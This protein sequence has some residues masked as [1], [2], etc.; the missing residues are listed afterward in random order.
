MATLVIY[1][2]VMKI[3]PFIMSFRS[4]ETNGD[5]LSDLTTCPDLAFVLNWSNAR[6][7]FTLVQDDYMLYLHLHSRHI[8]LVQ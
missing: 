7:S 6:P 3:F 4:S 2:T 8:S 5:S 1:Y